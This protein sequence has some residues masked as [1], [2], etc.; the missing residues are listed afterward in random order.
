MQGVSM[1]KIH[2]VTPKSIPLEGDAYQ[3]FLNGLALVL[4]L[5]DHYIVGAEPPRLQKAEIATHV[6]TVLDELAERGESR[7]ATVIRKNYDFVNE[8]AE[9]QESLAEFIDSFVSYYNKLLRYQ[10]AK[11][12]NTSEQPST[13][14][15]SARRMKN[16]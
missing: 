2:K 16:R 4:G 15:D 9:Q 10:K 3:L 12:Q 7:L 5:T 14:P 6:E 8:H 11:R 1:T 13:T